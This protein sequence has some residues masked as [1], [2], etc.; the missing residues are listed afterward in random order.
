MEIQ[1]YINEQHK[2]IVDPTYQ[3]PADAWS[4]QDK[5]CL[6]DTILRNE[7]MPLFFFNLKSDKGIFYIVDGQQRLNAILDFYNNKIKLNGKFSGKENED[8]TFNAKNPISDKQREQFLNYDLRLKILEDYDDERVRLIFSR[9]QRGRP[10]NLGERLNAKPGEIVFRMRDIAEH[11]FMKYS[12]AVSK[13]RYGIFPDAARIL[14]YEIY[15]PKNCGSNQLFDFFELY[16]N[17]FSDKGK[18][19]KN[20]IS[21]L[22]YLEKC[23]P[24]KPG[25]YNFLEKH[26][27]VIGVYILVH[28]L[29][30]SYAI[31]E[32][33]KYIKKF[34]ENFHSKVYDSDFRKSDYTYQK[35]YDNV[36][37]GWSEKLMKSRKNTLIE[38]FL[39]TYDLK[40][41]DI[42]RQI[43]DEEKIALYNKSPNCQICG[44][45]F[46]D[47]KDADYHHKKKF[48]EGGKTELENIMLLCKKCHKEIHR[49]DIITPIK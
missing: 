1:K 7:P 40:E 44:I 28:E 25:K 33:E 20:I 2:Y 41:L 29:K 34:I 16:Q 47:Y 5:Q 32:K 24:A 27:W 23:F 9:L 13:N 46:K 15:G 30:N 48:I 11:P 35:F 45:S 37:G 6:I 3:R 19:Y 8:K 4:I 38:K 26:V 39:E 49:K 14:F 21:V 10:L 12:T 36:R 31:I 17:N 42:K 22:N 18:E 43:S